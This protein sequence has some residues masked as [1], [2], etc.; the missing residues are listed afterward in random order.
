MIKLVFKINGYTNDPPWT[1]VQRRLE[2]EVSQYSFVK[3]IG[4]SKVDSRKVFIINPDMRRLKIYKVLGKQKE[5]DD[6]EMKIDEFI[7]KYKSYIV[8]IDILDDKI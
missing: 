2:H 5:I 6:L 1:D 4:T 7:N 3:C 8:K